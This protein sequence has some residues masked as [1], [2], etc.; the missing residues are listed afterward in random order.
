MTS[1]V[2]VVSVCVFA[3]IKRD[4]RAQYVVD[5]THGSRMHL[6]LLILHN[7]TPTADN[8]SKKHWPL[9]ALFASAILNQLITS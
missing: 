8:L 3:I 9:L 2:V 7:K 6:C 5:F 1:G 4:G